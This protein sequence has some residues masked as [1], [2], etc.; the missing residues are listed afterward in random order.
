MKLNLTGLENTYFWKSRDI[1][2]PKYNI[3]EV[4]KN[5]KERPSWVHF[6]A[7]NIFRGFAAHF[8]DTLLNEGFTDTGIIAVDTHAIESGYNTEMIDKV[9]TPFDNLTLLLLIKSDGTMI[10]QVIGSIAEV[11][12]ADLKVY[13]ERL[14]EIFICK[15]L[16][17][18]SFTITEKGYAIKDTD[19]NYKKII[20]NDIEQGPHK[21]VHVMSIVTSLL[22]E[23]YKNGAFKV[24][25]VS[26]DNCSRNGDIIKKSVLEIAELWKE[27]GFV[28][29]GFIKYIENEVSFPCSMV[30]KITPRPSKELALELKKIDIEN[31]DVF[32]VGN[33]DMA[34]FVNAEVPE[35][36]VI[37]DNFP[38]G[39]PMF[40][41]VHVYMTDRATV[42]KSERMKVMTCLNPLH[43]SLAV[44]GCLLGYNYIYEEMRNPLLKRLVEKIGYDEGM[45]V[46]VNP[47]ILDPKN[48]IK[49]V[50]EERFPN[51]FIPD[52]PKRIATD[53]SQ[54]IPVRYGETLKAYAENN[55]DYPL[56]G[57]PLTIAAWLRYLLGIDDKGN[58]MTVSPDP[59]LEYL[60]GILSKVEF[61]KPET[62]KDNL[63][64][65]L[66][67]E[68]LFK[69]NLYD[70][71]LLLGEKIEMYFIEMI[72]DKGAIEK[73]LKKYI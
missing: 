15:S 40:E 51:P 53:T 43:T 57:I 19:N 46:V 45:K 42:E 28:D 7:G 59:M 35:Y 8:C 72:E 68:K 33:T 21:S 38:N 67:N 64:P 2:I 65:I 47:K 1:L 20:V 39:R 11:L 12:R 24:A 71:R 66:S 73:T 48:F 56:I 10:K 26:M 58:I 22:F 37:E 60:Q 50:I 6:G 25:F 4:V 63:R 16:Q 61:R 32:E 5:T 49:E 14:K 55:I 17:I 41:K 69:V 54:K 31:M 62:V 9:Y 34:P 18:V 36:L 52:T 3:N 13:F 30:D 70:K 27:K 44:F 29:K 23:R